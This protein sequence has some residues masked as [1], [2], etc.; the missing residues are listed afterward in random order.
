V[1][2]ESK[3]VPGRAQVFR[4]CSLR[5]TLSHSIRPHRIDEPERAVTGHASI[6]T[7]VQRC[8]WRIGNLPVRELADHSP[9]NYLNAVAANA[10]SPTLADWSVKASA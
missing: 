3:S 9:I 2:P 5:S 4:L 8:S 1:V 6:F 7:V 10:S